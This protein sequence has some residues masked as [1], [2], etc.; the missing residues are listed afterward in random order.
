MEIIRNQISLAQKHHKTLREEFSDVTRQTIH[1]ALN[2]F[3]K[4]DL[5][6]RIRA[7]AKEL[8]VEEINGINL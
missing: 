6:K 2:D 8:L 5:A 1:N 4:S 7:R 3:T